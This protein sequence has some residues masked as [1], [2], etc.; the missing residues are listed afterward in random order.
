MTTWTASP[1]PPE[2]GR[3]APPLPAEPENIEIFMY[4]HKEMHHLKRIKK[5][6]IIFTALHHAPFRISSVNNAR[7]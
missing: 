4:Q 7:N 3:A 2:A 6:K 1:A 5:I